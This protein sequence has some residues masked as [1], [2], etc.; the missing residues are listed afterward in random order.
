MVFPYMSAIIPAS[1]AKH[2]K[3][4]VFLRRGH[5]KRSLSPIWRE[6]ERFLLELW[7]AS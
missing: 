3:N 6:K 1:Q 4:L 5:R 7:V 2:P